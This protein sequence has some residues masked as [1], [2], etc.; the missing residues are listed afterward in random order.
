MKKLT[1]LLL[2]A[3]TA[4][5]ML[6]PTLASAAVHGVV[7]GNFYFR[8]SATGQEGTITVQEGDRLRFTVAEEGPGTP[9]SVH[10]DELG[11][12]YQ[13]LRP[14][15]TVTTSALNSPGS[16]ELYCAEHLN[17]GHV[18]TLVVQAA[19][20]PAQPVPTATTAPA[21]P[22]SG[23]TTAPAPAPAPDA[24]PE[25][26]APARSSTSTTSDASTSSGPTTGSRT[27]T[28]TTQTDS[29]A[30][31][32]APAAQESAAEGAEGAAEPTYADI[33]VPVGGTE[34]PEGSAVDASGQGPERGS[35]QPTGAEQDER[36][37][38]WW[39]GVLALAAASAAGVV[40]YRRSHP[41]LPPDLAALKVIEDPAPEASDAGADTSDDEQAEVATAQA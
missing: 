13:K 3:V 40:A 41:P 24:E 26:T 11:I 37:R 5:A 28:G 32:S 16:Y 12:H 1:K 38:L 17:R 29:A 30:S 36:A 34:Q 15:D 8:D 33:L 27:A 6:L 21:S 19:P 20:P 2:P 39:I 9:H 25:Q 14:G 10:I 18:A 22:D 7:V 4:G 31:G 35:Q 23:T